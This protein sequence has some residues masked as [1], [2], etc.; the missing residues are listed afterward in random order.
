MK[1]MIVVL[2]MVA[3]GAGKQPPPPVVN[4]VAVVPVD[5]AD[6]AALDA[7]P[8]RLARMTELTEA[9]CQCSDS[10]CANRLAEQMGAQGS[11]GPGEHAGEPSEPSEPSEADSKQLADL[12]ERLTR[13]M[14]DAMTRHTTTSP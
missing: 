8:A 9:M 3:C 6:D 1:R 14:T 10:A 4:S 13:C 2:G 12:V 5:A 7:Q 11:G